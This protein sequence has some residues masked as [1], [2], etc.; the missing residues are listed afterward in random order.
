MPQMGH[1]TKTD[2]LTDC[3]SQCDFDFDI[4][5]IRSNSFWQLYI[6]TNIMLLDIIHRSVI[7]WKHRPV[8]FSKYNV[9]ETGLSPSLFGPNL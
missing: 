9:S 4:E 2:R 5:L 6:N 3:Q 8:Y 1:D 7:I